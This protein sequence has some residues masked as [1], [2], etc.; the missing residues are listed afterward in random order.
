MH[1]FMGIT[2][3]V[4]EDLWNNQHV[5]TFEWSPEHAG[6]GGVEEGY[7]R[8]ALDGKALGELGALTLKAQ[9]GTGSDGKSYSVGQRLISVEPM[10]LIFN[11]AISNYWKTISPRKF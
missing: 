3:A 7:V 10:Y 8:W 2:T 1:D 11:V 6:A 9:H 5:Y 4:S